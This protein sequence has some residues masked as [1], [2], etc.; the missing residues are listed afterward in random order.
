MENIIRNKNDNNKPDEL[1]YDV[2]NIHGREEKRDLPDGTGERFPTPPAACPEDPYIKLDSD[3]EAWLEN[4]TH[5]HLPDSQWIKLRN[6]L[7]KSKTEIGCCNYF[8][9]D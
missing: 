5:S 4:V 2:N 7:I 6:V 3:P 8:K 9:V 1:I